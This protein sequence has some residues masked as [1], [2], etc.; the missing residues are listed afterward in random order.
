MTKVHGLIGDSAGAAGQFFD[1]LLKPAKIDRF[2]QMKSKS[3]RAALG[4]VL[5]RAVSGKHI[6][7]L[8]DE[9]GRPASAP[10]RCRQVARCR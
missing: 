1:R 2:G 7:G 3:G 8:R 10:S 6:P 5:G 9:T 4:D